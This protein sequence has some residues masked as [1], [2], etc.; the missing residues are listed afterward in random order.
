MD[1]VH[2]TLRKLTEDDVRYL[3]G[4]L[5]ELRR[6][7]E[8]SPFRLP[9]QNKAQR[10]V[11]GIGVAVLTLMMLF[12]P[13]GLRRISGGSETHMFFNGWRVNTS[14]TR[15]LSGLAPGPRSPRS[16]LVRR[17]WPSSSSTDRL[18][19]Q[20]AAVGG[21]TLFGLLVFQRRS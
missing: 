19:L 9:P 18:M 6:T 20:L 7:V 8:A 21:A 3:R 2:T 15:V 5:F 11:T 1:T 16:D 17:A 14:P 12:P 13:Y 10:L 4:H